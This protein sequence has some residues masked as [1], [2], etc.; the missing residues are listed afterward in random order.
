MRLSLDGDSLPGISLPGISLPENTPDGDS[1]PEHVSVLHMFSGRHA[2]A[3]VLSAFYA[4]SGASA[5]AAS[6]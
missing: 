6:W 1:L 2:H 3:C 5:R 4:E